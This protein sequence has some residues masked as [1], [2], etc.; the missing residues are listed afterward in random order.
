[1]LYDSIGIPCPNYGVQ[2]GKCRLKG[3][4][5]CAFIKLPQY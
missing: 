5:K 1:M 2:F 3:F 4:P